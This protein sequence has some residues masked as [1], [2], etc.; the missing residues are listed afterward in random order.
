MVTY[1]QAIISR[2]IKDQLKSKTGKELPTKVIACVGGGSNAAGAFYEFYSEEVDLIAVEA[3]G[4][5]IDTSFSAATAHLGKK[6]VLHG[7]MT[8][9]MQDEFGQ[10]V[11]PHSISAGLDYPGIGPLHA[12]T[13]SE[14]RTKVVAVT[15]EEALKAAKKLSVK[16]G[17]IPALETAHALAALD[18]IELKVDDVVVIN[19]SGRGDK[20][21]ETYLNS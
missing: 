2:E 9:L 15:D 16:E 8:L 3:G 11:E 12:F 14:E 5:G 7:S 1:F 6:G 13:I 20:D 17:I 10:V 4:K 19:L 21:M 18:N